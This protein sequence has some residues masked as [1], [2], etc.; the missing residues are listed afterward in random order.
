MAAD[1]FIKDYEL[2][3]IQCFTYAYVCGI[4]QMVG[5]TTSYKLSYSVSFK[6]VLQFVLTSEKSL[7][8]RSANNMQDS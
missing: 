4:T 6:S 8:K 2:V 3:L 7:W 1:I 5:Y